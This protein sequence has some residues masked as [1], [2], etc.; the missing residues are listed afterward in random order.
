MWWLTIC[1][2]LLL[3]NPWIH[4]PLGFHSLM[5]NWYANIVNFLITR[6]TPSQWSA[7]DKKCSMVEICNF[8]YDDP[9]LFKYCPNQ[10]IRRCVPDNEIFSVISF[11]HNEACGCHFSLRKNVGKILQCGFYWPNMFKD[12]HHFC[13]SCESCQNLGEITH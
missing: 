3:M 6:Q 7:Q 8:F 10:I 11:F 9:Y 12:T 1:L 5:N 13:K 2:A 4:C